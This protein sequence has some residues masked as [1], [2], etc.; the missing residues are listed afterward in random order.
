MSTF[1]LTV[2]FVVMA[3]VTAGCAQPYVLRN[4]D[5]TIRL[6]VIAVDSDGVARDPVNFKQTL[7]PAQFALQV[8][9]MLDEMD[10]FHELPD[11]QGYAKKILIFAHGGLN[12]PQSALYGADNEIDRIQKAHYYPIFVNWQSDLD[13]S[14]GEHLTSITQGQKDYVHPVARA[15]VAPLYLAADL[16]RA[17]G[18]SPVV[19]M[20]QAASDGAA[21]FAD[22]GALSDKDVHPGTPGCPSW[23]KYRGSGYVGKVWA[24]LYDKYKKDLAMH[25]NGQPSQIQISIGDDR[26][27][28]FQHLA[29]VFTS[30]WL[31]AVFKFGTSWIID[32]L[33]TSAWDNMTRRTLVMFEGRARSNPS[34]TTLAPGKLV[35]SQQQFVPSPNA[36]P[37]TTRQLATRP[38]QE[39]P[40]WD[41]IG[42]AGYLKNALG[43]RIKQHAPTD[44]WSTYE[45]TLIGHSMGAMVLD[46]WVRRNDEDGMYYKNIVYMGAACSIRSFGET[47]V[48]YLHSHQNQDNARGTTAFYNLMLHPTAELREKNRPVVGD[49]PARGSLLV[50]IDEFFAN[51]ATSRDRT[52]GRWDNLPEA[53]GVMPESVRGQI[54]CRA[55][56]LDLDDR[57]CDQGGTAPDPQTHGAFRC[58][59]YWEEGFWHARVPNTR[60]DRL[61]KRAQAE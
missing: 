12:T 38:G 18:R 1:N 22:V 3:A 15:L 45:I 58:F 56:S 6:H 5:A 44:A 9:D 11:Q 54:T 23:V 57:R 46:E 30:Y 14:Y 36:Q 53:I 10:R 19:W 40:D 26:D 4:S 60:E 28:T 2:F 39:P 25:P 34:H 52:L 21:F 24:E 8:K 41:V 32:G 51:P 20:N 17:I 43:D 7:S 55:M 61:A 33:G 35:T 16:C 27:I 47:V 49:L 13:D 29:G 42:A 48:P 50:W 59:P 31:T 37:I